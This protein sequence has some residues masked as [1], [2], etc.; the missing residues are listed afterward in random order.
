MPYT[1]GIIE[2]CSDTGGLLCEFLRDELPRLASSDRDPRCPRNPK[3]QVPFRNACNE[4]GEGQLAHMRHGIRH[5]EAESDH[6]D[7]FPQ[8]VVFPIRRLPD[9]I[10]L[11]SEAKPTAGP[12]REDSPAF[13]AL[14]DAIARSFTP[15]ILIV[16]LALQHDE[17][18]LLRDPEVGGNDHLTDHDIAQPQP[19]ALADPREKLREL[20][21]FKILRAYA[22]R[23]PVIVTAYWRN[24]L[25][26]QHCLVSGG[27]AFVRKPVPSLADNQF[28]MRRASLDVKA[29]ALDLSA[30]ENSRALDVLVVDYL[31][32]VANEVLKALGSEWLARLR[33]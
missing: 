4:P 24:P 10:A 22:G 11:A 32:N 6:A 28:D 21:G 9:L 12:A 2:D 5:L 26:A 31:T 27:Y 23:M 25:V 8:V 16:D 18:K 13:D 20:T 15:D 7:P 29:A 3:T 17:V 30:K 1:V 19:R 14:R 33:V